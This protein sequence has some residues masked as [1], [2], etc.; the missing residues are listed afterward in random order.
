MKNL[1][2]ATCLL[3]LCGI[4]HA[5][6]PIFS[7]YFA[8][9]TAAVPVVGVNLS[10]NH[11]G[12]ASMA[13][14]CDANG[15]FVS[16]SPGIYYGSMYALGPRIRL[17][18]EGTFSYNTLHTANLKCQCST[19]PGVADSFI[20]TSEIQSTSRVRIGYAVLDNLLPY[21]AAGLNVGKLA[22]SYSNEIGDNYATDDL[23]MGIL[24][25]AGLEWKMTNG[26]SLRG[27]YHFTINHNVNL[28]LPT[29]YGVT[30]PE[31]AAH[32]GSYA[33]SIELGS[34]YWF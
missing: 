4:S 24:L 13:G 15:S 6:E 16:F 25:G 7:G 34:S 2:R 20:F 9:I 8:G 19:T 28:M 11:V 29:I 27:Q 32:A 26:W 12:F 23:K 18:L 33:N 14:A 21:F 10:A 17:A 30:D 3:L 22:L 31:G 5:D 1:I